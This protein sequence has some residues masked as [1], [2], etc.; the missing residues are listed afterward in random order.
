MDVGETSGVSTVRVGCDGTLTVDPAFLNVRL[1]DAIALSPSG[2]RAVLLG[3]QTLF[4]PV[5]PNDLRMLRLEGGA[6]REVG[7]FDV[8]HD[9]IKAGRIGWSADGATLMVANGQPLS[10]EHG[11]LAV[12]KADGDTLTETQRLTGLTGASEVL[13]SADG[14]TAL[15]S[16]PPVNKVTVLTSSAGSWKVAA[17][18]P[19]LGVIDQL[20]PITTGSLAGTVLGVT[21]DS[22]TG[23]SAVTALKIAGRGQVTVIGRTILGAGSTN[24]ATTIGVAP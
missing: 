6:L 1:S 16:R 18:V 15:V 13:F 17:D 21:V 9:M 3:G 19:G 4:D 20:A 22:G 23:R 7:A 2:D 14:A 24:V 10:K 5:D 11:H 12:L 8:F